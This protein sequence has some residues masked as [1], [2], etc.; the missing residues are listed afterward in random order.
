MPVNVETL[1]EYIEELAPAELA[2]HGDPVGLQLGSPKQ[3]ISSILVTLELD[4]AV[5]EAA[6]NLGAEMLV[7]YH[8]L[9]TDKRSL[10][11]ERYPG[12]ALVAS[13]M[14]M[15]LPVFCVH[16]NLD[17]IPEGTSYQLAKKLAL[18]LDNTSILNKTGS[19]KLLKLVL[20]VPV[21]HEDTVLTAITAAGA[22]KIG[23]YS[24]CTFQSSGTGTFM[25][26]PGTDPYLGVEGRL[27]KVDEYRLETILPASRQKAVVKALLEAH[28]YE[29]VAYD[30]Y[31]LAREGRAFGSG[32]SIS[33]SSPVELNDLLQRCCENLEPANLRYWNSDCD[34]FNNIAICGGRSGELIESAG[35]QG[36]ELFIGGDFNNCDL[37]L[38]Q[39]LGIT[40]VDVGADAAARPG[41]VFLQKYLQ[42]RLEFDGYDAAVHLMKPVHNGWSTYSG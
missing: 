36:A 29:E 1:A 31:L 2:L 30:I 3:E 7:T 15:H 16:S 4:S 21:G 5:L 28:P 9:I 10:I 34:I 18:P 12:E 6:K 27:E 37:R 19:E 42:E 11:N 40:L 33:L 32:L 8:P 25:P 20:F 35:N 17:V 38:A 39:S 22:G 26:G 41:I 24:H 14:R 23:S 13:V